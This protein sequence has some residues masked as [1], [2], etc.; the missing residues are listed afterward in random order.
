VTSQETAAL[1]AAILTLLGTCNTWLVARSIQ[2]SRQLNGLMTPRIT[3]GAE[4]AIAQDHVDRSEAASPT[5]EA[6]IQARRVALKAELEALGDQPSV[7]VPT[8]V[9]RSTPHR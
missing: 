2:H 7:R 4:K 5:P 1:V 6:L 9:G 8:V 3:A